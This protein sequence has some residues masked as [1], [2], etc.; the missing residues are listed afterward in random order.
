[1][2]AIENSLDA[3]AVKY[4][5]AHYKT[6]GNFVTWLN[7]FVNLSKTFFIQRFLKKFINNAFFNVFLLL[8][9][10][11]FYIYGFQFQRS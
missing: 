10:N 5:H 3:K 9:V 11:V 8:G 2:G 1:M 7:N 4:C 6:L